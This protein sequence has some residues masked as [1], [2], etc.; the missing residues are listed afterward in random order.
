MHRSGPPP[1][2]PLVPQQTESGS[3]Q[4]PVLAGTGG[5]PSAAAPAPAVVP[6]R[7]SSAARERRPTK[8]PKSRETPK[9]VVVID[10]DSE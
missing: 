1:L 4:H 3:P 6:K 5:T 2:L 9:D 8:K 10:S 7:G